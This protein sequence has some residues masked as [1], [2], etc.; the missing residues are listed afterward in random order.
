[1]FL[2]NVEKNLVESSAISYRLMHESFQS[3]AFQNV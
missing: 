2:E 1:M 3:T